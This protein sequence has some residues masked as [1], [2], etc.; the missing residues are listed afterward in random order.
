MHTIHTANYHYGESW[1]RKCALTIRDF[2]G[3]NS[4]FCIPRIQ[5]YDFFKQEDEMYHLLL[6]TIS[7]SPIH[8]GQKFSCK[9]QKYIIVY[10]VVTPLGGPINHNILIGVL[11]V[12][13]AQLLG[14]GCSTKLKRSEVP[15][16]CVCTLLYRLLSLRGS[17]RLHL[18]QLVPSAPCTPCSTWVS[19]PPPIPVAGEYKLCVL[20]TLACFKKQNQ[21]KDCHTVVSNW[22]ASGQSPSAFEACDASLEFVDVQKYL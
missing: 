3:E 20:R 2:W 15:Q 11:W 13:Y 16:R 17:L 22:D 14:D 9:S 1:I 18:S 5:S 19:L 21:M 6:E 8:K 12:F 7:L 10:L 4:L